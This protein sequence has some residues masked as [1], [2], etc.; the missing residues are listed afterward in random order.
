M[1]LIKV[2]VQRATEIKKD[3]LRAHRQ[4][5]LAD[6]DVQMLRAIEVSDIE[7]QAQI[8][9]KKQALRDITTHP[10]LLAATTPEELKA[11]DITQA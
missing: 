1:P 9:A 8:L 6:L 2:N 5:L 11:F 4:P 10:D 3:M 7:K